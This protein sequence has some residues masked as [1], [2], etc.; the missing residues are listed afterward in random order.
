MP[1]LLNL[2]DQSILFEKFLKQLKD[3]KSFDIILQLQSFFRDY[4]QISYS[5]VQKN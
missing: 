5:Y 1:S 2:K 3:T 4:C